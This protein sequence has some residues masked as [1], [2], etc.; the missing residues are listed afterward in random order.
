[1]I[2]NLIPD[3]VVRRPCLLVDFL[4]FTLGQ[5]RGGIMFS[6]AAFGICRQ[7]EVLGGALKYIGDIL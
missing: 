4:L 2:E 1:M 7:E 5:L 3:A 6:L